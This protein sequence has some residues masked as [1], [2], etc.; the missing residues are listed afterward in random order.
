L[1]SKLKQNSFYILP[2]GKA[3]KC[4]YFMSFL[5][6]YPSVSRKQKTGAAQCRSGFDILFLTGPQHPNHQFSSL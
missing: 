5:P 3:V 6:V 4:K 2:Y 1:F